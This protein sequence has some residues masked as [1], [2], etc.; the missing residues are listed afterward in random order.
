MFSWLRVGLCL[1][2]AS[3]AGCGGDNRDSLIANT[4]TQ[5]TEVASAA[6][7]IK[8]KVDSFVTKKEAETK[9]EEGAKKDLDD[10]VGEAKRLKDIAK[11]M[12]RL[13]GRASTYAA[14]TP[15]EMKKFPETNRDRINGSREQLVSAHRAM[16]ESLAK[17]KTKYEEPLQ[18]LMQALNDA[19]GEF[20][21]ITRRK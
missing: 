6:N 21:A 17:A 5:M 20:V 1:C 14:P 15:E 2:V 12:Q 4:T 11:E 8:E 7:N 19:E 10:A 3:L 9:D 18:P 13:S 16:K